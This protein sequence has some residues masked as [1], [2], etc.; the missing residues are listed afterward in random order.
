MDLIGPVTNDRLPNFDFH[1]V[2]QAQSVGFKP[3]VIVALVRNGI[4]YRIDSQKH[5]KYRSYLFQKHLHVEMK[6]ISVR[7]TDTVN[8]LDN[9]K[10][11]QICK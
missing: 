4:F 8:V 1:I 5:N 11:S 10:V 7:Q 6:T 9:K 2:R 3:E